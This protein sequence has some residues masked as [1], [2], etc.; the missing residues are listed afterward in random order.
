MSL[1]DCLRDRASRETE[2]FSSDVRTQSSMPLQPLTGK[3][4]LELVVV[5]RLW[6][7]ITGGGAQLQMSD[8]MNQTSCI[9]I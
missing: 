1:P 8:C 3:V 9:N 7:L 4:K 5:G 2:I 6:M